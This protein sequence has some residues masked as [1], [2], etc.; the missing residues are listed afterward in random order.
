MDLEK[1]PNQYTSSI[2]FLDLI[3]YYWTVI[4]VL[5]LSVSRLLPQVENLPISGCNAS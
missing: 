2:R 5:P 3:A 1:Y 4:V